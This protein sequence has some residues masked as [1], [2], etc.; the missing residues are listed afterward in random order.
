MFHHCT[1]YLLPLFK[2]TLCHGFHING[3]FLPVYLADTQDPKDEGSPLL[4]LLFLLT[5]HILPWSKITL[6]ES[7]SEQL[8][9]TVYVCINAVPLSKVYIT[10]IAQDP[11]ILVQSIDVFGYSNIMSAIYKVKCRISVDW[12]KKKTVEILTTL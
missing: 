6:L 3:L 2:H 11:Q 7:Y 12:K 4:I 1:C 9:E 8:E 10:H 5:G